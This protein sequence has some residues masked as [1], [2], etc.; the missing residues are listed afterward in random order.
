M[1]NASHTDPNEGKVIGKYG[2][3]GDTRTEDLKIDK[4]KATINNRN[5]LIRLCLDND[6]KIDNTMFPKPAHKLATYLPLGVS[7][8]AK[9]TRDIIPERT[10]YTL[11]PNRN[12]AQ[13][14]KQPPISTTAAAT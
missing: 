5:R 4:D 14:A 2:L 7:K 1:R 12:Q 3:T 10:Q 6:L 8:T 11:L 13:K 9:I